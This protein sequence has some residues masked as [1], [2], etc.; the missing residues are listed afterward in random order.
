MSLKSSDVNKAVA[1]AQ[2]MTDLA[3]CAGE[4]FASLAPQVRHRIK[5]LN[6]AGSAGALLSAP[7]REFRP[8][9]RRRIHSSRADTARGTAC[10]AV[11]RRIERCCFGIKAED[12]V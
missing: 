1:V 8:E 9:S 11:H 5:D 4:R 10:H 6:P 3:L 12:F 7:D 2:E